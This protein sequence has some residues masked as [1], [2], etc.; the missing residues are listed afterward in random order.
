MSK[1]WDH[2]IVWIVVGI[3]IMII[4]AFCVGYSAGYSQGD[5]DATQ[6]LPRLI[7][8]NCEGSG[9]YIFADEEDDFPQPCAEIDLNL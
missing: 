7:G 4:L 3:A 1:K 9:N 5:A 2:E 8:Y 6:S